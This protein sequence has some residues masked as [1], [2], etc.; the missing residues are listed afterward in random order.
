MVVGGGLCWLVMLGCL[1]I[2]NW[3]ERWSNT[4]KL[5]ELRCNCMLVG[6]INLYTEWMLGV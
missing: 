6:H 3:D 4:W 5:Y 2:A 1:Q